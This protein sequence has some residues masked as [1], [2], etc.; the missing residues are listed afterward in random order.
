[1]PTTDICIGTQERLEYERQFAVQ[2]CERSLDH[3][4]SF[5]SALFSTAQS[6]RIEPRGL[7]KGQHFLCAIKSAGG[8]TAA[9]CSEIDAALGSEH[10]HSIVDDAPKYEQ[11]PQWRSALDDGAMGHL[12]SDRAAYKVEINYE[13]RMV[14]AEGRP[15]GH[16]RQTDDQPAIYCIDAEGSLYVTYEMH[17]SG[18]GRPIHHSALV[19]GGPI[20]AAG[21][22]LIS[23]GVLCMINNCSGHYRPPPAS[24]RIAV[25]LLRDRRVLIH[26]SGLQITGFDASGSP[27][28][29]QNA[30]HF[31]QAGSSGSFHDS[32]VRQT[33]LQAKLPVRLAA[34]LNWSETRQLAEKRTLRP[35]TYNANGGGV[36]SDAGNSASGSECMQGTDET[37]SK[38][39]NARRPGQT[40]QQRESVLWQTLSGAG[41]VSSCS[42]SSVRSG[43]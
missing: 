26:S 13:G 9:S 15:V 19:D 16:G 35:L 37:D 41:L 22:M 18:D 5:N 14:G 20:I 32:V 12:S 27:L 11:H 42:G 43:E 38:E 25:S 24:L 29:S 31:D 28:A 17:D 10:Q 30:V 7:T 4:Q 3:C 33:A 36:R 2:A 21:E 34:D 1:M 6:E 40:C 39:H 8:S 23:D